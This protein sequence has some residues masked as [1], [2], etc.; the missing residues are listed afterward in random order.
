MDT[1]QHQT[2]TKTYTHMLFFDDAVWHTN[3]GPPG[4][5]CSTCKQYRLTSAAGGNLS[6]SRATPSVYSGGCFLW[7][8]VLIQ[9]LGGTFMFDWT[10]IALTRRRSESSRHSDNSWH[11]SE[12]WR[13]T[14]GAALE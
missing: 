13:R 6:N 14:I 3:V 4:V 11:P 5:D 8:C 2:S 12:R 7:H 1:H 10:V 9:N